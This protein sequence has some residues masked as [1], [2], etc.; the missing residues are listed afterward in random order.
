MQRYTN[1]RLNMRVGYILEG[2]LQKAISSI[3][4]LFRNVCKA[5]PYSCLEF[6]LVSINSIEVTKLQKK[7]YFFT[8]ILLI[9]QT[10]PLTR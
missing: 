5:E 6:I 9:P 1:Y 7:N 2:Y 3:K 8:L 4:L 10:P